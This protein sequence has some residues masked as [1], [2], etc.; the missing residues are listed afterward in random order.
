[1]KLVIVKHF[2]FLLSHKESDSEQDMD[3][4]VNKPSWCTLTTRNKTFADNYALSTFT[5]R[6]RR[7]TRNVS[8]AFTVLRNVWTG[9]RHLWHYYLNL[10]VICYIIWDYFILHFIKYQLS[11]SN[12]KHMQWCLEIQ[13]TW[14]V[15]F[16]FID[17]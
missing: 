17:L 8:E 13:V 16:F 2:C 14:L 4:E 3:D 11:L 1:M 12:E 10:I 15:S 6:V 9:D 5:C 7:V